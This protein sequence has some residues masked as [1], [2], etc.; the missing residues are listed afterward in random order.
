MSAARGVLSLRLA[1]RERRKFQELQ[2]LEDA[3]S[4]RLLRLAVPCSRCGPDATGVDR[5]DEHAC[6]AALITGYLAAAHAVMED[7]SRGTPSMRDG[8]RPPSS[9]GTETHGA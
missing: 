8:G 9:G 6:D 1:M 2:S 5:C 7:L 3:I 4:F